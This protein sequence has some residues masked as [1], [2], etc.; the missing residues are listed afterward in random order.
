[1]PDNLVGREF[2]TVIERIVPGGVG[3]AHADERT[4]FVPLAA[5]GDRL[6]VRVERSRGGIGF[7]SIIEII[8]A[9]PARVP[10]P[11]PDLASAGGADFQ[12]L[13]YEAQLT[14]KVEM[15]RDSLRRVAGVEPPPE[16]PIVAS[17]DQWHYRSR[18]EWRHDP[19]R[20]ALGHVEQGTHLVRDLSEDPL[21]VP[22]LAK[23]FSTLRDR[24]A[25][26][27]LSP[28]QTHF[29]AAVAS[30]VVSIDPPLTDGEP[31]TIV[32][33]I[34]GEEYAYDAR[35][36]FQANRGLLAPLVTEALRQAAPTIRSTST[37]GGSDVAIDLFCGV[38]LFTLPLARRFGQ[39]IGVEAD[40]RAAAF[41]L[42]NGATAGLRNIR[43]EPT[44]AERWLA[45]AHRSYGRPSLVLLDPPRTGLSTAAATG[46]IRMRPSRIT[47]V[48]CDPATLA[49]DL[50]RLLASN[51]TLTGLTAFDM[52][53]QTHHVEIV[54]HLQRQ[55]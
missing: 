39:V 47:Y 35:C 53:P 42:R 38:G 20:G 19:A 24:L 4:L 51:Y 55:T 52:F 1:L 49:R 29:R 37:G 27:L 14:A 2:E 22:E 15:I 9:S 26:G 36:F 32:E 10:P 5:P 48:S 28:S 34:A 11:Y 43:I 25:R 7:A 6:R 3:L 50:R 41:A 45:S 16:M 13:A 8:E 12:H 33:K 31:T 23:V 44:T 40:R 54:A 21:V 17:P 30:G 46:I 18:A